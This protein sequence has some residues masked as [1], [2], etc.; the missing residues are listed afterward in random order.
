MLERL[1]FQLV[2]VLVL[3]LETANRFEDEDED[4]DEKETETPWRFGSTG[5][6]RP[7]ESALMFAATHRL[8][9]TCPNFSDIC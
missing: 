2:L 6:L 4:E 5:G 8:Q 3:V 1:R 9:A 7:I